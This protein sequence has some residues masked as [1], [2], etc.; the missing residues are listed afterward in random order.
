MS[1]A[2]MTIE[3]ARFRIHDGAESQLLADRGLRRSR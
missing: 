3:L 2:A 1:T